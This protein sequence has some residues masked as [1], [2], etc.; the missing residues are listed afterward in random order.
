MDIAVDPTLIET[1][2]NQLFQTLRWLFSSKPSELSAK[3]G[4]DGYGTRSAVPAEGNTVAFNISL[5]VTGLPE[6]QSNIPTIPINLLP[7]NIETNDERGRR[8]R[9]RT[10]LAEQTRQI[11]ERAERLRES[12]ERQTWQAWQAWQAE[13]ARQEWQRQ[14]NSRRQE[15]LRNQAV[16][17][18]GTDVAVCY[19]NLWGTL[20]QGGDVGN[21]TPAILKQMNIIKNNFMQNLPNHTIVRIEYIIN[22]ALYNQ[23]NNTKAEFRKF[24]RNTQEVLLFHGTHPQ[25]VDRFSNS[26]RN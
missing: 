24:G 10:P 2:K 3:Q 26:K 16:I 9:Q 14:E 18:V 22:D 25:N 11:Q 6:L 4:E 7:E 1:L 17:Q 8:E 19:V 12:T 21:L 23:F 20:T 15:E 13:M 5:Q